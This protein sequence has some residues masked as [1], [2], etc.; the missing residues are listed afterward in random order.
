MGAGFHRAH[1][2]R[3]EL[4]GS[5]CLGVAVED[6]NIGG[7]RGAVFKPDPARFASL[8]QY[9]TD[10]CIEMQVY[11]EFACKLRHHAS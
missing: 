4:A 6:H 8:H 7:K 2:L 5:Q 9:L 11:A 10:M 1:R 3:T